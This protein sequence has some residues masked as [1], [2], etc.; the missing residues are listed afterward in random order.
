MITCASEEIDS[1]L[2]PEKS[3]HSEAQLTVQTEECHTQEQPTGPQQG[4]ISSRQIT[5]GRKPRRRQ[6][7]NYL[8]HTF[9]P[10]HSLQQEQQSLSEAKSGED[11]LGSN[12][13]S[14]NVQQNILSYLAKYDREAIESP[15][16]LAKKIT[17]LFL[18]E[19]VRSAPSI[20]RFPVL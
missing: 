8:A 14:M 7:W 20:C 4:E 3:L 5:G 16:Q 12:Y 10:A 18:H 19:C 1:T 6:E 9:L 15:T 13:S 17:H 11:S 2:T